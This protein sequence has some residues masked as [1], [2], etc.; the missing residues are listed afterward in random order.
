M[1]PIERIRLWSRTLATAERVAEEQS[2][3]HGVPIDVATDVAAAVEEADIG[4]CRAQLLAIGH[5]PGVADGGRRKIDA[6]TAMPEPRQAMKT[7]T[8]ITA[9]GT[10]R[11]SATSS[12]PARA[13]VR[14]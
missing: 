4:R 14:C 12:P 2:A 8:P 7:P 6:V 1:R 5:A 9:P 10:A 11:R 13:R 3:V